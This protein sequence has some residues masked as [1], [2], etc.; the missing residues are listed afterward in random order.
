MFHY[1]RRLLLPLEARNEQRKA[2]QGIDQ[3][4]SKTPL[5]AFRDRSNQYHGRGSDASVSAASKP[6][7]K[8]INERRATSPPERFERPALYLTAC[9]E[10][11]LW[12]L[13]C[14]I[15]LSLAACFLALR[16][17]LRRDGLANIGV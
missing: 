14:V 9:N 11:R 3:H 15:A 8:A 2:P 10:T 7:R 12:R 4:A 5:Q 6:G 16:D 17:R 1:S 13:P